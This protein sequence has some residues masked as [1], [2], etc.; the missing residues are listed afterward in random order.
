MTTITVPTY[1]N[2][3]YPRSCSDPFVLKFKGEYWGYCTGFWDDGRCF[4]ILHSPDLVQWRPLAGALQPLE[5]LP[6]LES[7]PTCYWAP[8]VT[9]DNGIFYMY[10]SVGNERHMQIRV[11]VS[12]HPAGP[13]LDSGHRLT[14]EDFAIDAHVF[15][16]EDGTRYLFYA[17]DFLD[18]THI[19][20][21]T[22][23]DR[24][25]D[26]FTLA[27]E[28]RPVTR[29][30]FDWQVYDPQRKEKGGV[31]WHT[32]E[33]PFVLKYKGYYY[34]MFSGG[35]WQNPGY[36]VSYATSDRPA[37]EGEWEQVC[38]GLRVLPILRSLPEK[39]VIGPGHN[40]V[41]RGPDNRQLFCIYHRWAETPGPPGCEQ[42]DQEPA[43]SSRVMAID[44]LEWIGDRMAVLGPSTAP[45]PA[46]IS[47]T[48]V[49]FREPVHSQNCSLDPGWTCLGG[50]WSVQDGAAVQSIPYPGRL[51]EARL[52]LPAASFLLEANLRA[53][54]SDHRAPGAYG[55]LLDHEPGELF[56]LVL[57]PR[58]GTGTATGVVVT[59]W[60]EQRRD[61]A[62]D[63]PQ[64]FSIHAFHH[65][66]LEVNALQAS[67][68]IDS[69]P[70]WRGRLAGDPAR[71]VLF[72]RGMAAAFAALELTTGWEDLFTQP[73]ASPASLGWQ[74]PENGGD[75]LIHDRQL[76]HANPAGRE[77]WI[78]KGELLEAYE[79]VVNARLSMAE[80]SGGVYG[81]YPVLEAALET[82]PPGP[83]LTVEPGSNGWVLAHHAAAGRQA[84]PL[85]SPFNPYI[86]QQFRFRKQAGQ[87]TLQWLDYH[88]GEVQVSTHPTRIG[89]YAH[90]SVAAFSMV[91]VTAIP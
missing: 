10:Y 83:L 91:R 68:A 49:Y 45:Q 43:E 31:R 33:G 34:Q 39:G 90:R 19:G 35:N 38:D 64:D 74:I 76:W 12:N 59:G 78:I 52:T 62:I 21:G 75:W 80:S 30:R 61:D 18:H 77:S 36:G 6:P 53:L 44:R 23:S 71:A 26:P 67:L 37:A 58:T 28:P 13:Y 65:V 85:P 88:L 56:S 81:F 69:L 20:T 55:I 89:L 32:V 7:A 73:E 29:A 14:L 15:Q 2:S 5:V 40:S 4:G 9:Y 27:R 1:L 41:V 51:S 8:E 24:L 46:P 70:L 16:D 42:P 54:P 11:A 82:Q 60:G 3:V 87:L 17:T 63:L 84:F 86:D 47:P 72:T 22:V 25:L 50:E 79:Y 66:R 48:Q 57:V